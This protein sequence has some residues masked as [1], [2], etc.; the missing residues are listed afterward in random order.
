MI[1]PDV[2]DQWLRRPMRDSSSA[3]RFSRR[4]LLAKVAQLEPE[5]R[6]ELE[7]RTHQLAAFLLAIARPGYYLALDMGC[8]KSKVA[9]D[10]FRWRRD[11]GDADSALVLVPSTSNVAEWVSELAKHSPDV[12]V[13]AVAGNAGS[14]SRA[15]AFWSGAAVVVATYRGFLLQMSRLRDGQYELVSSQ[16]EKAA[17]QFSQLIADESTAIANPEAITSRA[18]RRLANKVPYRLCLSGTPFSSD[19][20]GLWPQFHVTDRGDTL[21]PT[22]GFFRESF[23]TRKQTDY[24]VSFELRPSMRGRLHRVLR[25]G[26][27]RY[28]AR[29]CLTLPKRTGGI[30]EPLIRSVLM[31]RTQSRY[32]RALEGEMHEAHSEGDSDGVQNVY[33][34]MRTISSGYLTTEDGPHD[35]RENPKLDALAQLLAEAP[36]EKWVVFVHY[37]HSADLV[38]GML[39]SRGIS[40]AEISGRVANKAAQLEAFRGDARVLVGSRAAMYGLN[41]QFCRLAVFFESPDSIATRSQGERRIDRMGQL[42]PCT[43]Y[44]LVMRGTYDMRILDAL[45][46]NKRVLDAVVDGVEVVRDHAVSA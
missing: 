10:V 5:P 18:V 26:S 11:R 12:T 1:D 44:D 9:I 46:Q 31:S 14:E 39:R 29:E 21:G 36:T 40:S 42:R 33:L 41:L 6:F 15:R 35:F 45:R 3:K 37:R 23:F 24:G 27:L 17:N 20:Q 28:E 16:I 25:H 19:P 38:V 4:A 32:I 8:G 43:I 2:I 34:R 22:F 30:D 7:P 13:A